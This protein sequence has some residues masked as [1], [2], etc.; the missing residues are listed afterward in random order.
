MN[1][2]GISE[3]ITVIFLILVTLIAMAIVSIYYL[4]VVNLNQYGLSQEL[5]NYYITTGQM[6]SVVYYHQTD[7]R[8]YFYVE[9]IGNIPINVSKIYVNQTMVKFIIYNT[10][11][12]NVRILY[13]QIVYVI[14][15]YDNTTNIIIQTSNN[16]LIQLEA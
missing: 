6:V 4:H 15:V 1:V 5:K 16:N 8:S 10:T 14:E 12:T 9:N 2:K 7:N 3:A 13:P 11:N